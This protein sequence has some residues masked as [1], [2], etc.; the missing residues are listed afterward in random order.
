MPTLS[1]SSGNILP[2]YQKLVQQPAGQL[3]TTSRRSFRPREKYLILLV[4]LTFGIVCFGAFFFLPEDLRTNSS[5]K[6]VYKV[7]QKAGPE[8]LI[9]APPRF[10]DDMS[11]QKVN[12]VLLHHDIFN[13]EDVHLLADKL[14]LKVCDT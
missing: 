1:S 7:I 11:S 12:G 10:Q 14:K 8:L 6:S 3:F 2:S 4:L 9:P 5:V 13:A